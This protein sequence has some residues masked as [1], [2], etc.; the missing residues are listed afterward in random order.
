M[1][2]V[3]DNRVVKMS[4]VT[5]QRAKKLSKL[6]EPITVSLG[7][8]T[9]D[10]QDVLCHVLHCWR[11]D[12]TQRDIHERRL[13]VDLSDA[14][15]NVVEVGES[16]FRSPNCFLFVEQYDGHLPEIRELD[17]PFY[18]AALLYSAFRL[19]SDAKPDS[20]AFVVIDDVGKMTV[21][22][23]YF[24]RRKGQSPAKLAAEVRAFLGY[25]RPVEIIFHE[26]RTFVRV[27][28]S[29]GTCPKH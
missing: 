8:D 10:H 11:T 14:L 15:E 23:F 20:E 17:R 16:I 6:T 2:L 25:Q 27:L 1:F 26:R 5:P 22:S 7:L 29:A 24:R 3:V 28:E 21:E 19:E 12:N 13:L 4:P 18:R 9:A